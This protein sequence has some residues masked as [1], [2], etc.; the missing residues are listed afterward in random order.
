MRWISDPDAAG[1]WLRGRLDEGMTTMHCVVPRGFEAYARIFHPM[2]VLRLPDGSP[3]PT[4]E[5][6]AAL[7][8]REVLRIF[9]EVEV[10]QATW[11]EAADAFGTVMH[12]LAQWQTLVRAGRKS[13]WGCR[14]GSDGRE[15][16]A[17]PEGE[18]TPGLLAVLA[19]HLTAH[20]SSPGQ[21]V[22]GVWEGYGGLLEAQESV[23]SIGWTATSDD[24]HVPT[25]MEARTMQG[26][27][28]PGILP[29]AVAKGRRLSL[30][31]RDHVLFEA[32]PA[33][34]TDVS[35]VL[36]APWR[37]R[38]A[39]KLGFRPSAQ[40]PNLLWPE[41]RAW[42][43]VSEIDYDSTIIAGTRAL[44]GRLCADPA[45][46]AFAIAEGSDLTWDGDRVNG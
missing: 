39:E 13:D 29:E 24:P 9:E 41:D 4:S 34:F 17:P 28:R 45:L 35:W 16:Q 46:E 40:H 25:L 6:K 1:G 10:L 20:T 26:A 31:D 22:A 23:L 8:D 21:G 38:P 7:T 14:I 27:R 37:D 44:I 18:M 5:D 15:Y 36:D 32:A 2:P 42:V 43:M 11:Q 30:F 33:R 12:P 3:M 19:G